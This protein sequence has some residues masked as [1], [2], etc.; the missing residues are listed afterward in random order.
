M[1][2]Q[3][4]INLNHFKKSFKIPLIFVLPVELKLIPPFQINS[5]AF[6]NTVYFEKIVMHMVDM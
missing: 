5:F 1:L 3:L 6:H 4:E 2:I